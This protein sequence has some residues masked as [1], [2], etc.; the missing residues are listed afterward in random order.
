[1]LAA[2]M[3]GVDDVRIEHIP[4]PQIGPNEV[5]V[6]VR[7]AGICGTDLR[8]LRNG[9]PGIT[10]QSPRVLG[11]EISGIIAEV[12]SK[13]KRFQKNMRVSISPNFGCGLCMECIQGNAHL[14]PDYQ[15]LGVHM[16]GG[17]AEYVRIPEEMVR[18]GN[19]ME[20]PDSVSFDEAA[21]NE[22]VACVY[23]GFHTCPIKVGDDVL[24]IG[25]GPIG[26]M[27]AQFAKL[28]GAARV[29]IA[30]RSP[31]RLS[32]V[33]AMDPSFITLQ[34]DSLQ[35]QIHR[36]TE[37]RGVDVCITANSN[38]EA[39]QVAIEVMAMHGRINFFGGLPK[40]MEKVTLNSNLIHYRQL[41]I[42][43]STRANNAHYSSAM[44]L[45]ASG[46]L[47]VKKTISAKFP[48]HRFKE[49]V[50]YARTAKG[51]KTL[52]TFE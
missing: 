41:H 37:G 20:I 51:M 9:F 17:F 45:I 5:L 47:E 16:H 18:A 52:I 32:L 43:G 21:I 13:V 22:L 26:V 39:Q 4:V 1:M 34:A 6:K 40:S 23:N 42:T 25:A 33:K 31:D 19:V 11:H 50:E 29:M 8:M 7:S 35:E 46:K 36:L 12:G 38:P 48:I 49:A 2:L 24:I 3:Y 27:F 28:A 10:E 15:A 30:N 44:K 14:C